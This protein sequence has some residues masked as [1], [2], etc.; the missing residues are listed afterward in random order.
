MS[1]SHPPKG[2][3]P[4][5]VYLARLD[6]IIQRDFFPSLAA[7]NADTVAH[8]HASSS[9]QGL[10]LED[11][12]DLYT[13]DDNASFDRLHKQEI[14]EERRR[15]QVTDALAAGTGRNLA[16]LRLALTNGED[17]R[18]PLRRLLLDQ[19]QRDG[20]VV[21]GRSDLLTMYGS[22][23]T[24]AGGGEGVIVVRSSQDLLRT[25]QR[26][27]IRHSNTS[28]FSNDQSLN[29]FVSSSEVEASSDV[30]RVNGYS[31]VLTPSATPSGTPCNATPGGATPN[32]TPGPP[33]YYSS[34][35]SRRSGG[36]GSSGGS[37]S[38]GSSGGSSKRRRSR[39]GTEDRVSQSS[40]SKRTKR[41]SGSG[42]AYSGLTPAA[43]ALAQRLGGASV[44]ASSVRR[45]D[46]HRMLRSATPKRVR[47]N[48]PSWPSSR[49]Q[50]SKGGGN[51]KGGGKDDGVQLPKEKGITD[52]LLMLPKR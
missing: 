13:S 34:S 43:K 4:E 36:G 25:S 3:L 24:A 2:V 6:A 21:Q 30:M 41:E 20:S 27:S 12:F 47:G 40:S 28:F 9:V 1:S 45:H 49:N 17:G 23:D 46:R 15:H 18:T 39:G 22:S 10:S 32:A 51:G 16:A 14:E 44:V 33:G 35:G 29:S 7:T 19:R 52:G 48:V 8:F 50:G 26:K 42:S 5:D 38:G 31:Y 37:S 11:F